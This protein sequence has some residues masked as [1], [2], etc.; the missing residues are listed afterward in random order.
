MVPLKR[1]P[2]Y[3]LPPEQQ[4]KRSMYLVNLFVPQLPQ[5]IWGSVNFLS[6]S[7]AVFIVL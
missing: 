5:T 2:K 3:A 1:Q 6:D 4:R 7:K